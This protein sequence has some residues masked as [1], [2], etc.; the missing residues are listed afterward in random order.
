MI[1]LLE[2]LFSVLA[3]DTTLPWM[4]F[5]SWRAAAVRISQSTK[6]NQHEPGQESNEVHS[7]D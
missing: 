7:H 1:R 4:L 2:M 5:C 3:G 6:E